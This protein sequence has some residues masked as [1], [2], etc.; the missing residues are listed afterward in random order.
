MVTSF[1]ALLPEP[2]V[3]EV[4]VRILDAALAEYLDHGLRR[5]SVDEVARRAG[6][7]RATLYR[8]FA[9][10]DELVQAV[11][12]RESRRFFAAINDAVESLPTIAERLVEGFVVGLR[13]ARE[14][15]L[16]GR[17]LQSEPEFLLPFLTIHG[18]P[19]IAI[20]RQFMADQY[21]RSPEYR[22]NTEVDPDEF[23]EIL[24]RLSMSLVLTPQTCLPLE[25]DDD[26]RATARR[27]FLPLLKS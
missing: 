2:Q 10:R 11:L 24:V 1:E 16:L 18:G 13:T 14:Q 5:T 17:L 25:T 8:R 20:A 22:A 23:A 21:R 6:L 4:S 19:A 12:V 9:S 15:P 3:D 27:Y 7:G 26:V